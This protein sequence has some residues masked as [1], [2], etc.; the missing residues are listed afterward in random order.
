MLLLGP[1]VGSTMSTATPRQH[2]GWR[3]FYVNY[4]RNVNITR[5]SP[6]LDHCVSE[7]T[8]SQQT[9]EECAR[10]DVY[11]F[12]VYSGKSMHEISQHFLREGVQYR[13]MWGLDS[14][15]GF[16]TETDSDNRYAGKSFI[17]ARSADNR[18]A[19]TGTA[20]GTNSSVSNAWAE[21]K[22]SSAA[23][24]NATSLEEALFLLDAKVC[25]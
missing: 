7:C 6:G 4:T 23:A 10:R 21:G 24:M 5:R 25:E 11:V 20:D 15:S 19:S 8:A 22:Y 9:R 13:I 3:E 1:V 17:H 18:Y 2:P 12:G 16:P 14:F